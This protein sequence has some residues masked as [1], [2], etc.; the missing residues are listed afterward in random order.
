MP[1]LTPSVASAFPHVD[2]GFFRLSLILWGPTKL[3]KTIWARSLG[4]HSYFN[5]VINFDQYDPDCDYAIFDDIG[6]F[7]FFP[8]YKAWLGCQEEFDVNEKYKRKK[9]YTLGKA[10]HLSI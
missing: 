8:S 10:F 5:T 4:N 2:L 7:K 1:P 6:G 9:T 3:G